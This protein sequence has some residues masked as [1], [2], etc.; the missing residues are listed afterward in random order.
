MRAFSQPA[1][2]GTA[3]AADKV[4]APG[5][6]TD[7]TQPQEFDAKM[8][9]G[10]AVE[11]ADS[12]QYRKVTAAIDKFR[13]RRVKDARDLL[14][15]ARATQPKLPP[16]EVLIAKLFIVARHPQLAMAELEQAVTNHSEDPEAYLILADG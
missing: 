3:K 2:K 13:E 10:D 8:L 14:R 4:A 16:P 5:D 11:D 12:P 7:S 9:I 1:G 6:E 15:E